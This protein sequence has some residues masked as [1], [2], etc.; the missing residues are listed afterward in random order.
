MLSVIFAQRLLIEYQL[1]LA[2][3]YRAS[4]IF[5]PPQIPQGGLFK[6]VRAFRNEINSIASPI[7]VVFSHPPCNK[8]LSPFVKI[9]S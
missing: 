7:L 2:H 5:V 8:K 4:V 3:L 6:E 9:E 1:L